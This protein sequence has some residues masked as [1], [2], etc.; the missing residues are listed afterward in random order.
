MPAAL[1]TV[2]ESSYTYRVGPTKTACADGE[3]TSCVVATGTADGVSR[4]FEVTLEPSSVGGAFSK[5][6][7]IGDE[8]A[9]ICGGI[10]HGIGKETTFENSSS[11]CGGYVQTEGNESLPP[12]SSFIPANITSTNSVYRLV[13]CTS[14]NVP[15]G[16]QSDSYAG[17]GNKG[18][19]STIPWNATTRTISTDQNSTLTGGDYFVCKLELN[20]NSHLIIGEG[21]AVRIFFDTPEDCGS[22]RALN[23]SRSKTTPT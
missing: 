6:G 14:T 4:R 20:N 3:V 16:C 9:S 18:F 21:A 8:E 22:K 2:G 12:V 7:V 1:G 15:T 23:R 13:K 5:A 10:R 19:S 11:Q 17:N